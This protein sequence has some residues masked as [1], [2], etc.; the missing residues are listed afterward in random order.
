MLGV[1]TTVLRLV[2]VRGA[3]MPEMGGLVTYHVEALGQP[4]RTRLHPA[5]EPEAD[6]EFRLPYARAGRP[7]ELVAWADAQIDRTGPAVRRSSSTRP[8]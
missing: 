3:A 7:A 2:T 5:R 1:P 4:D 8:R 6:A